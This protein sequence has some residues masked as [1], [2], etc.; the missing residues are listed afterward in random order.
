MFLCHFSKK[1]L[2]KRQLV[3]EGRG[4]H[5][6]SRDLLH[7]SLSFL[8]WEK[9]DTIGLWPFPALLRAKIWNKIFFFFNMYGP[10]DATQGQLL[11]TSF[12]IFQTLV[13][14]MCFCSEITFFAQ[15]RASVTK[16][17][18]LEKDF[19]AVFFQL[20][21]NIGP[22]WRI[23][24]PLICGCSSC[25]SRNVGMHFVI[26]F[27]ETRYRRRCSHFLFSFHKKNIFISQRNEYD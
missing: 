4:Q 13:P 18:A 2:Q 11:P 1:Y 24:L 19:L 15:S 9:L 25:S 26:S 6:W 20:Q 5:S 7:N 14:E 8:V 22:E 23:P 17:K 16:K 3:P 10:F 12:Q 21:D 27:K